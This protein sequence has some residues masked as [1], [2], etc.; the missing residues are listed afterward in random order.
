MGVTEVRLDTDPR[1]PY[2]D[3]H[4]SLK[5]RLTELW[6]DLAIK[7]NTSF[8]QTKPGEILAEYA[9]DTAAAAGGINVGEFYRTGSAVKQRVA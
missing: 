8:A 3:D 2:A 4:R 7:L 6:R 5:T 1:L 9:D